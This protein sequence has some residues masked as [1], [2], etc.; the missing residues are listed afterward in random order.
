MI[1]IKYLYKTKYAN[2]SDSLKRR[3]DSLSLNDDI[4]IQEICKMLRLKD[5]TNKDLK[6]IVNGEE[7]SSLW[8]DSINGN[9]RIILQNKLNLAKLCSNYAKHHSYESAVLLDRL[10]RSK[11]LIINNLQ[12][13][14]L[15]DDSI[16]INTSLVQSEIELDFIDS[17]KSIIMHDYNLTTPISFS[18]SYWGCFL[19]IVDEL[20]DYGHP[21]QDTKNNINIINP[22]HIGLEFDNNKIKFDVDNVLEDKKL[23]F[24]KKRFSKTRLYKALEEKIKEEELNKIFL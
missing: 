9:D 19:M 21:Y 24:Y 22:Y 4:G 15:K 23:Q 14:Q 2:I 11:Q 13:R 16:D 18:D 7:I 5:I 17:M 6:S 12:S 1:T 20:Q 8:S 3:F 10:L